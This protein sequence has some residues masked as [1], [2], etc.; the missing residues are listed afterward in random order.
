[1]KRATVVF[2][3]EAA[4]CSGEI[5]S[6]AKA[7]GAQESDFQTSTDDNFDLR[8]RPKQIPIQT[9]YA[10]SQDGMDTVF[11]KN[12]KDYAKKMIAGDRDFF[13]CD[14]I[15]D[16]A[17]KVFMN[18]EPYQPLLSQATVDVAMQENEDK[19]RREYYNIPSRDGGVSQIVKWA[20]VR[21]N[22][23][24]IIPYST[25][26]PEN[27]IVLAFDPARTGDNSILS[28]MQVYED[29]YLGLCGD[30][31]NC[32]NF[33]DI[34]SKQKYKLDSNRQVAL[35]RHYLASYNG[36][37][38]DY[39]FIDSF[40]IDAGAGGGGLSTYADRLLEDWVDEQG[41][42]HR[43]LIDKYNNLYAGYHRLYPNAVDKLRL[44]SPKAYRTQMVE[45]FIELFHLG[46]IHLPQEYNA[47]QGFIRIPTTNE[48]KEEEF[49]IYYLSEE[50]KLSFVQ[51]DLMKTELTSIHK[52]TNPENTSVRYALPTEKENKMHDDRFY[53]MLLLAHRLY[54]LRREKTM[55]G[56]KQAVK[57]DY[58]EILRVRP[59][60]FAKR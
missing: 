42:T 47:G 10:S 18:G 5:L 9:I 36:E 34:A 6:I 43:G 57:K 44:I 27:R 19:A 25:W 45:E 24:L 50:E 2:F 37:N 1:M 8:K 49:E 60:K 33:I 48:D 20:T 3:D 26:K 32:V 12:Y 59:P 55:K 35:L 40:L 46:V 4:F 17:I 31:I 53:T 54:E 14:M 52:I 21:N 16:T 15:C 41:R 28:A 7:F 39:E 30:V 38:P 22:E 29:P 13:V 56:K 58:T 11:Y 51:L 23:K